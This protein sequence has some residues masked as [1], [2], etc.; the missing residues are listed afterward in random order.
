VLK[1]DGNTFRD[2]SGGNLI[3]SFNYLKAYKTTRDFSM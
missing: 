3:F 1:F 2:I